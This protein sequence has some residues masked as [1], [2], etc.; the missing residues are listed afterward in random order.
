MFDSIFA[1]LR[2]KKPL[3]HCITNYVTVNDVANVALACGASPIMADDIA[4]AADITAICD[5]LAL[6]IGTLNG[7]TVQS[8][9]AAG[10]RAN[11]LGR[12]VVLDPVGAGASPLRTRTA[13]E[14][15]ERL[16]LA[17]IRG[18]LSEIKAVAQGVGAAG[19]G[20]GASRGV[21]AAAG[22]A[23]TPDN[24]A[25][26]AAFV[27]DLA[28]RTGAVIA[29]TGAVDLVADGETCYAIENGCA[30]MSRVTGTGC[31]LT[32]V[33]AAC[34][35]A[36]PGRTLEAAAAAVAAMGLC[37]ELARDKV[38]SRGEGAGSLRVYLIDAMSNLTDERLA[39]GVKCH[40]L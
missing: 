4:E 18:N 26:T 37:G 33:I 16:D 30:D 14:L 28:R 32:A 27:K 24:Q 19:G 36:H 20:S 3:V 1:A 5:A 25:E 11:Q 12:P 35:A 23:V 21:D 7:R 38:A 13:A 39:R 29:A 9:L 17:V 15:I 34:V 22:D 2:A 40:A 31:M 8:M 6:N 10:E